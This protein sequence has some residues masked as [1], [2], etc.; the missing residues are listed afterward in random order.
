MHVAKAS[1]I[2]RFYHARSPR[3]C[4]HLLGRGRSV[5]YQ[6]PFLQPLQ[7]HCDWI[8]YVH[9]DFSGQVSSTAHGV[10]RRLPGYGQDDYLTRSSLL[11]T[12]GAG[13]RAGRGQ[14][15]RTFSSLGSRTPKTT[16]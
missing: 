3:P 9:E 5:T 8:C 15:G 6:E 16:L 14:K 13:V 4:R 7:A 12:A 11:H 10:V 1:G 2:E